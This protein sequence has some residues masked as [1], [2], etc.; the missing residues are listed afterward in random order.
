M[1]DKIIFKKIRKRNRSKEFLLPFN[2][3][4]LSNSSLKDL[5]LKPINKIK[6]KHINY[7]RKKKTISKGTNVIYSIV[8]NGKNKNKIIILLMIE[9]YFF[10]VL[11]KLN[12]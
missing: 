1:S 10:L 7:N 9:N 6:D 2:I 12:M 4:N 5:T 3:I 11:M 8:N